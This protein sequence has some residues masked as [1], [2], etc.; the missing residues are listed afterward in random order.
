MRMWRSELVNNRTDDIAGHYVTGLNPAQA[1]GLACVVCRRGYLRDVARTPHAPVARSTTGSQ[2]FAC[3]GACA[4]TMTAARLD[5][6]ESANR[7]RGV[8][9]HVCLLSRPLDAAGRG[10][11]CGRPA[12]ALVYPVGLPRDVVAVASMNSPTRSGSSP[13]RCRTV[14]ASLLT[15]GTGSA[16][17]R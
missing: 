11:L 9:A 8:V 15:H 2:V 3:R 12:V 1:D 5:V 4:E 14:Q 7:D 17:Q 6:A 16:P 10:R 13:T